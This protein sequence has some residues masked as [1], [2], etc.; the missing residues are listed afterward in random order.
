MTTLYPGF[1]GVSAFTT[2]IC[3]PSSVGDELRFRGVNIVDLVGI[4]PYDDVWRLLVDDY[5]GAGPLAE[6]TDEEVM[7]E[8]DAA[9]TPRIA[10]QRMI[11]RL[12][13]MRAMQPAPGADPDAL[14]DDLAVLTMAYAVGLGALLAR[15]SGRPPHAGGD[16]D[17]EAGVAA[18]LVR[19]WRGDVDA[20][21]VGVVDSVLSTVAEHGTSASTFTARVVASTGAD[22]AACVTAGLCAI[23]GPRHGGATRGVTALLRDLAAD[24]TQAPAY[25][26]RLL[27]DGRRLPGMG[28][29]VYR[30]RDPRVPILRGLAEAV[31]AP[32]IP[33]AEAYQRS[34]EEELVRRK[35]SGRR[36]PANPDLWLPVVLDGIGVPDE[37]MDAFLAGARIGGWSAHIVEQVAGGGPLLRPDDLYVGRTG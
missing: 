32:L 23:G 24:P 10:L 7:A 4:R 34:A 12:G 33:V 37:F 36:L 8:L 18:R 29:R 5:F 35:G 31:D 9:G 14:R 13:T 6:I 3:R 20:R 22:A 17:A 19:A 30:E 16:G 15:R 11:L 26:G 21:V 25:V 27:D 2:E 1:V 28:H